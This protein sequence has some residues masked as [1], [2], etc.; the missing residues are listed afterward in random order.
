[1]N[2][3]PIRPGNIKLYPAMPYVSYSYL[4]D[5]DALAIKAYLMTL[6]PVHAP[7]PQNTLAL[8]FN[9]Q[10]RHRALR[11]EGVEPDDG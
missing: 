4:S 2:L 1:L 5:G 8:L 11:R 3:R 9:Q 7:A 6:K 10:L